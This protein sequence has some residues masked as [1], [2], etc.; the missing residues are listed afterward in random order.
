MNAQVANIGGEYNIG[1]GGSNM[2]ALTTGA[3]NIAIG[4]LALGG[5]TTN[6]LI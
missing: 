1:I 4:M 3:N 5:M 2:T 6:S